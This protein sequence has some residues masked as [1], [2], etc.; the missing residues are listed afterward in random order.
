MIEGE[1]HIGTSGWSYPSW[2]KIFYPEDMKSSGYLS[3]YSRS[4]DAVEINSSFYHLPQLKT[5]KTWV[6]S[7]PT[8]FKFCPKMSRY[9]THIKKLHE[10]EE[11]LQRFF[12][13]LSPARQ[14]LGPVLIQLPPALRFHPE[15]AKQ[16]F[17]ALQKYDDKFHFALEVR[18]NSWLEE[19]GLQLL[20]KYDIAFVISQSAEFPYAEVVTSN[21]VYMRFHGPDR[22]Y[23]SLYSNAAL[24]KYA[25][26]LI[27]WKKEGKHVWA[28]FNNDM[29]GYA[30]KNALQLKE[31]VS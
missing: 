17:N 8:G 29:Q 25:N 6:E 22:L 20:K 3:F 12:K 27:A 5:V 18:H 7:V 21:N 28:F 14:I 13:A 24:R 23:G 31:L 19:E 1:I 2:K 11:P 15:N 26:K 10:P 9:L 30:V 16:F 4:F